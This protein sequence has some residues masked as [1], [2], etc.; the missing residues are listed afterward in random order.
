MLMAETLKHK[1][2]FE[3][4]KVY[5][6]PYRPPDNPPA[7]FRWQVIS[8]HPEKN[9]PE[10]WVLIS[11]DPAVPDFEQLPPTEPEENRGE[12]DPKK[13]ARDWERATSKK[14]RPPIGGA[15]DD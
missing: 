9:Y 3:I 5:F 10:K 13:M 4:G 8:R 14:G 7:G 1:P 2:V 12:I 11:T 15:Q 6:H